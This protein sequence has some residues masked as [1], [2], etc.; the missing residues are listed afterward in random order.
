MLDESLIDKKEPRPEVTYIG[1]LD[2]QVCVPEDWT[3][4]QVKSFADSNIPC[5]TNGWFIRKEGDPDLSGDPER[6]PCA[7]RKG[8]VHI[9]LDA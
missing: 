6:L 1:L 5:G 3:D 8:F 2:I 4:E 9:M 7:G